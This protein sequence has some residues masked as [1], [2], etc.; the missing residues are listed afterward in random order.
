MNYTYSPLWVYLPP[1]LQLEQT[2]K[3]QQG[4]LAP[5]NSLLMDIVAA[6]WLPIHILNP[7]S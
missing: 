1:V 5:G 7:L 4:P 2:N 3:G 6:E